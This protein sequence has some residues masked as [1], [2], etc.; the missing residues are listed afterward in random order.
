MTK[1]EKLWGK[2]KLVQP[3]FC[4][5]RLGDGK[6]LIGISPLNDR[7]NY[8]LLYGDS[9]WVVNNQLIDDFMALHI[10][11][12]IGT[13][14][15]EFGKNPCE[16][17]DGNKIEYP[18]PA[19]GFGNGVEFFVGDEQE[20]FITKHALKM[21]WCGCELTE[22]QATRLAQRRK[23]AN[24]FLSAKRHSGDTDKR[25][26]HIDGFREGCAAMCFAANILAPGETV[27]DL[28]AVA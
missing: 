10:D 18:W 26:A 28:L 7:P 11:E 20:D 17:D 3:A 16:D 5:K 8:Y 6:Q 4:A 15:E 21:V 24:I 19:F 22:V 25:L 27:A 1:K 14:E 9:S 2:K 23:A 13:L 12:I